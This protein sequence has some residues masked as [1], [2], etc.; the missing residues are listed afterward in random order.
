M[1]K[2][3]TRIKVHAQRFKDQQGISRNFECFIDHILFFA[4][5]KMDLSDIWLELWQGGRDEDETLRS[6]LDPLDEETANKL[7]AQAELEEE[8]KKVVQ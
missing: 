1:V 7:R 5:Y 2:T 8:L 4:G 3:A 6:L